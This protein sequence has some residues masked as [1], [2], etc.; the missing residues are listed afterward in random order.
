VQAFFGITFKLLALDI[1]KMT[2]K[3]LIINT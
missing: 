2:F 1:Y 3:R